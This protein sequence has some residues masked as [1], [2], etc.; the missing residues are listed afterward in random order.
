VLA[1]LF[2][3]SSYFGIVLFLVLTGC[4]MPIPEEVA[5]VLAGVLSAEEKL[6]WGWALL[7]CLVG[8][9]L[10]DSMMYLIGRQFGATKLTAHP[11]FAKLLGA[12]REKRF[13]DAIERHALKVMLAARFMVG[14]R[15]PVYLA[16]GA[17]RMPYRKFI[18]LDLVCASIVVS[19]VFG[20]SY[21]FGQGVLVWI[22]DAE[23][24]FTIAVVL[25]S[26]IAAIYLYWN[27][28][29]LVKVVF[30]EKKPA[31]APADPAAEKTGEN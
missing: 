15:G 30:G 31:E 13:E 12:E 26:V 17:I 24:T 3:P 27:R 6:Y 25:V 19:I 5:I 4:G 1:T 22:R 7:A 23:K 16:A 18:M 14:V 29:S 11:R 10:G 8:A 28:K 20:L 2:N 9:I 21:L